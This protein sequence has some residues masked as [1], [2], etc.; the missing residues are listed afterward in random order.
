MN[1]NEVLRAIAARYELNASR[2]VEYAAEDD[3]FGWEGGAEHLGSVWPDEGKVLYALVRYLKP[4]RV[5]EFGTSSGVSATHVA[6]AVRAN[7]HGMFTTIDIRDD[8]GAVIPDTLQ[9]YVEVV[10]GDAAKLVCEPCG[11]VF[12]DAS[13]ETALVETLTRKANLALLPGGFC[14]HHDAAH[15]LIGEGIREGIRRAGVEFTVYE[16]GEDSPAGI[17]GFTGLAVWQKGYGS[18]D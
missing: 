15:Y 7:G 2:L 10:I 13:H 11:F 9:P 16:T 1:A 14:V 18:D 12:E 6:A 3:W 4:E 8:A 17:H 5:Y